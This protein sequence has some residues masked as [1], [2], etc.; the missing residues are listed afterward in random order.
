[1]KIL[2][3]GVGGFVGGKLAGPGRDV[4]FLVR[5]NRVARLREDGLRIATS[6][7]MSTLRPAVTTADQLSG[8]YDLIVLAVKADALGQVIEDIAP[9]VGPASVILPFLNGMGHVE[10]L[11]R[12]FGHAL[13]GG[14][15]RVVTQLDDDGTIRQLAPAF[16]V[17]LGEL[18]G[19][20][21][22]RVDDI[23][24]A[25]LAAGAQVK[26]RGDIV[27]AMWAKWV[28]IASIGATTSLI[29]APLNDIT[30]VSGG[31]Q[32]AESV[33]AEAAAVAASAGHPV[34]EGAAARDTAG[35]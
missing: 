3:V 7:G 29:R 30:A 6:E 11:T 1:V 9:A 2:V 26:V 27:G 35:T 23:A 22:D 17:E 20:L 28:F 31:G 21:G 25:F 15:L 12:R 33:L 4:T 14:V 34:P 5:P 13:V 18:D 24:G 32:F 8:T 16:E 19:S 10:P